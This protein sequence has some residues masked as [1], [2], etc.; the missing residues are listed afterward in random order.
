[1]YRKPDD[2][3]RHDPAQE[4]TDHILEILETGVK[5][6]VR[7]WNPDDAAGPQSPFNRQPASIT[8]ASMCLFS[9]WMPA[10]S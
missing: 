1:M 7:P 9:A 4:V 10:L 6:W 8:G 5:P 3:P 2:Q